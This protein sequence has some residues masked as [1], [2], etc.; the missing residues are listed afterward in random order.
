M[1]DMLGIIHPTYIPSSEIIS[2]FFVI[3]DKIKISFFSRLTI[4]LDIYKN[5]AKYKSAM[6]SLRCSFYLLFR[7]LTSD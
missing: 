7:F 5:I 2:Y 3:F 4:V 6:F 1:L